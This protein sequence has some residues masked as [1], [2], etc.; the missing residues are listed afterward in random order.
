MSADFAIGLLV[1]VDLG[2]VAVLIPIAVLLLWHALR[3]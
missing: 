3:G 1:G 2:A